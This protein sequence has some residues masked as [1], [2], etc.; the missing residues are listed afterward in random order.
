[1]SRIRFKSVHF[2]HWQNLNFLHNY[3]ADIKK[4]YKKDELQT[5]KTYIWE[6][7]V[8]RD[9]LRDKF[10][11]GL[12]DAVIWSELTFIIC[13]FNPWNREFS[14]TADHV[15]RKEHSSDRPTNTINCWLCCAE[16][17]CVVLCFRLNRQPAF[18]DTTVR[19]IEWIKKTVLGIAY[20]VGINYLSMYLLS[21]LNYFK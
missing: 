1:M 3:A 2:I 14:A 6:S 13:Y 8:L 20:V 17:H 18:T 5:V 10:E 4:I 21:G 16:P 12:R 11:A 9:K 19:I 7:D 15:R